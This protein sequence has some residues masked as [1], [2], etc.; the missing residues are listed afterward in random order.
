MKIYLLGA[1]A[2]FAFLA[3][4]CGVRNNSSS[5]GWEYQADENSGVGRNFSLGD[6]SKK[7]IFSSSLTLTVKNMDSTSAAIIAI[8]NKYQGYVKEISTSSATIRIRTAAMDS[9]MINLESLGRV[10][11]KHFSGQDVTEDYSD[12]EIRL[13]NATK[14]RDRYLELLAKAENVQAALLVEKELERLNGEIELMKGKMNRIDHLVAYS[15]IT[16]YFYEKKKPGI[17][18]YIGIGL[19][20]AVKWLF[21]RN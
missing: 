19:W 20:K 1:M 7:I 11:Q 9:A 13:D 14:A 21:V 6:D 18:G 4:N 2:L 15:T 10:D 17:I 8:T 12:Y 16:V 5:T 3:T